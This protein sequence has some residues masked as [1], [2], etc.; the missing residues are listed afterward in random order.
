MNKKPSKFD[1]KDQG[2]DYYWESNKQSSRKIYDIIASF[3]RNHLIKRA[4]NHYTYKYYKKGERVLHAGCGSGQVDADIKQFVSITALDI[5]KNALELYKSNNPEGIISIQGDIFSMPFKGETFD[6]IYNLG[7]MEHFE[8][9]QIFKILNEFR[10]L[11]K[12]DG[13]ILIFWPPEFGLSVIFFK[14][15]TFIVGNIFFKKNVKFHPVEISR[16]KSRRYAEEIIHHAGFDLDLYNFGF[17]DF[18]TYCVIVA[19]KQD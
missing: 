16:I 15:L 17:R 6:G 11:L 10:R 9:D 13:K 5:S 3:Y 19:S 12:P 14:F 8:K 7:V 18:L 4:L 1:S 2:W